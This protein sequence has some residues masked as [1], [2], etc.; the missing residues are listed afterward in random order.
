MIRWWKRL[1][2]SKLPS[3]RSEYFDKCWLAQFEQGW[4]EQFHTLR[5]EVSRALK[6]RSVSEYAHWML[7]QFA[8]RWPK[9]FSVLK[10][11]MALTWGMADGTLHCCSEGGARRIRKQLGVTK[12]CRSFDDELIFLY[13]FLL[14]HSAQT[15]LGHRATR[16][17]DCFHGLVYANKDLLPKRLAHVLSKEG[18]SGSSLAKTKYSVYYKAMGSGKEP[19]FKAVASEFVSALSSGS[20][21][22][23]TE[24]RT[25]VSSGQDL[26]QEGTHGWG[27]TWIRAQLWVGG[28]L[29][30]T[31]D[32]MADIARECGMV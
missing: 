17:L 27:A 6:P 12:G 20:S 1:S 18:I 30:E 13:M 29:K 25:S 15:V 24:Q 22:S 7:T 16:V 10:G 5:Q 31:R 14:T 28:V 2:S 23:L 9:E 32:W 21:Q 26:W 11:E 3:T 4:P 8:Q 19:D